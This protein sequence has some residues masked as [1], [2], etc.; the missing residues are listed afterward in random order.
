MIL[1][2]FRLGSFQMFSGFLP[3]TVQLDKIGHKDA[4]FALHFFNGFLLAGFP[5]QVIR[6]FS[7]WVCSLFFSLLLTLGANGFDR[8]DKML[9]PLVKQTETYPLDWRTAR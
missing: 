7:G 4:I 1:S 2:F 3:N 6:Q 8:L 5:L 9:I